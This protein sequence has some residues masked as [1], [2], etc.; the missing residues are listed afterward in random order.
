MKTY[1]L[2]FDALLTVHLSI[3]SQ[4][5]HETATYRCDDTRG[6]VMQFWPPDDEYMCSKYVVAWNELIVKQKLCASSWLNNEININ[7]IKIK[8]SFRPTTVHEGPESAGIFALFLYPLRYGTFQPLYPPEKEKIYS[9]NTKLNGLQA[10]LDGKGR[11]RPQR[12][13]IPG[14]SSSSKA[15]CRLIYPEQYKLHYWPKIRLR[16]Y[17]DWN[18]FRVSLINEV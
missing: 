17:L 8:G 13:L 3:L 7:E 6:C 2:N 1:K 10:K 15:L 11:S 9:L 14:P 5:V 4:L 12:D 18:P 16:V